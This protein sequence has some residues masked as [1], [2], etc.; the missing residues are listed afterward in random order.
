LDYAVSSYFFHFRNRHSK[1]RASVEAA[2]PQIMNRF[3]RTYHLQAEAAQRSEKTIAI[4]YEQLMAKPFDSLAYCIEQLYGS[5]EAT[6]LQKAIQMASVDR[7][8]SHERGRE[9]A[10]VAAEGTFAAAHFVRSGRV[11]EGA[12]FFPRGKEVPL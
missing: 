5:L 9:A 3:C 12:E 7:L 4:R 10:V 6:A 8:N 1:Q 11:G 2:L